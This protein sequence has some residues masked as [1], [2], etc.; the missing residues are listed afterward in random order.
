[1]KLYYLFLQILTIICEPAYKRALKL[2]LQIT[3]HL[4]KS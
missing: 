2:I 4:E 1:M 3:G